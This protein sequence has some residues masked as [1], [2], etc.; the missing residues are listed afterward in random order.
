M[1][2]P[3]ISIDE[4]GLCTWTNPETPPYQWV[5]EQTLNLQLSYYKKSYV[6]PG[7]EESFD[8]PA[9]WLYKGLYVVLFGVDQEDNL[10]LTPSISSTVL[11]Y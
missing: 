3:T 10:I 6:I 1:S 4:F 9:S 2:S 5:I 7:S 11:I 8:A